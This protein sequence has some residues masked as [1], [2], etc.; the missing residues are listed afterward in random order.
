MSASADSQL[1]RVYTICC[2]Y[3]ACVLY[4]Y[5]VCTGRVYCVCACV[6]VRVCVSCVRAMRCDAVGIR[7]VRTGCAVT[8]VAV[9]CTGITIR[10]ITRS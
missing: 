5:C 3:T 8:V 10:V 1:T 6:R 2:V 9:A 7:G 4:V